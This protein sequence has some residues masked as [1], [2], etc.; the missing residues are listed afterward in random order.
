MSCIVPPLLI[1]TD[2]IKIYF[3][4]FCNFITLFFV[5]QNNFE[6]FNCH[7]VWVG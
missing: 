2:Y 4:K 6:V 1:S 7:H 5:L 3:T